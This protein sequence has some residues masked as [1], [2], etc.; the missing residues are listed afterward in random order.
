V[1][2]SSETIWPTTEQILHFISKNVIFLLDRENKLD[3]MKLMKASEESDDELDAIM[4]EVQAVWRGNHQRQEIEVDRRNLYLRFWKKAEDTAVRVSVRS[5]KVKKTTETIQTEKITETTLTTTVKLDAQGRPV[6]ASNT[7]EN[8]TNRL[9]NVN[10]QETYTRE[11]VYKVE[12]EQFYEENGENKIRR[13]CS[14]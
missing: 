10:V 2:R 3:H 1:E 9:G 5:L 7:K 14:D 6:E 8:T 13:F 4:S 11:T 12:V